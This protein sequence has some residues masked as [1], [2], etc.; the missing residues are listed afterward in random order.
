MSLQTTRL[1]ARSRLS[2]LRSSSICPTCRFNSTAAPQSETTAPPLLLKLKSD[3]KTSM[4][5][6]DTNR[7][8]VLRSLISDVNNSTKTSN[9]IKTDMQLVSLL[10]KRAA[11]AKEASDEFKAA[12]REDLVEKEEAQ[13]AVLEEYAGSVETMSANDIKDAVNK[14]VEEAK[15]VAQEKIN[16]GDVLKKLVGAGGSLEGNPVDRSE[17]AR[18]VKQ[19]LGQ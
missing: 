6:R 8:N 12:G 11:A 3:L 9:P 1:L 18:A 17:V 19:A 15:A 10:R 14:V 4:K 13:A 5:A 2:T 7:L 16:M